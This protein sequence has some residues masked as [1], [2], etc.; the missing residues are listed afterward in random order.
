MLNNFVFHV[1]AWIITGRTTYKANLK[2][3]FL[4]VATM[5]YGVYCGRGIKT[6]SLIREDAVS[7]TLAS[8]R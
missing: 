7:S 2:L 1:K 4:W 3:A 5:R 8:D 6:G